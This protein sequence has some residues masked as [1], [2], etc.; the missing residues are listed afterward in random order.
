MLERDSSICCES[1]VY[2]VAWDNINPFVEGIKLLEKFET[3]A[4]CKELIT[5]FFPRYFESKSI[6]FVDF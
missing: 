6:I 3:R 2:E 4:C 1:K 5:L